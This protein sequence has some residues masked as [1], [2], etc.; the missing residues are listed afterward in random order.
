VTRVSLNINKGKGNGTGSLPTV[1]VIRGEEK[2]GGKGKGEDR[3]RASKVAI[4][5]LCQEKMGK[6]ED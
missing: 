2:G 6:K 5:G 3:F 4:L 1:E